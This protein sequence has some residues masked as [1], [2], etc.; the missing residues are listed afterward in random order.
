MHCI[1]TYIPEKNHVPKEFNAA[2]I[3]SLLFMAPILLVP[4]LAVMY[5]YT[6]QSSYVCSAQYDS[7]LYY[8]YYYY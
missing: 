3:L 2:A 8:Y 7:F 6:F 4:A 1:Y 5:F